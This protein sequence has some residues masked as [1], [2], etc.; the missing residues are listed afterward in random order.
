MIKPFIIAAITADGFIA[1]N[2]DQPA[3]WTSPEDKKHF[4]EITKRAKVMIMG[5]RT[6]RT[7]GRALPGRTTIVYSYEKSDFPGVEFTK[8]EPEDLL[9]RLS[10]QGYEEVAICG[11]ASIYRMFMER[12]LVQKLYLTVE[13][14]LF[15]DGVPL[16][17]KPM[18]RDL[19]LLSTK[20]ISPNTI[21]L[22][23]KVS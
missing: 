5:E 7:I 15:G 18:N 13:A 11:G 2:P 1:Q 19:V 10:L 12:G 16:F 23:Y 4:I 6:F 14:R 9:A 21:V 22:E 20:Q 17:G 8:E 3:T